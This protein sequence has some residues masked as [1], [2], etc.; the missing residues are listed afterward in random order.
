MSLLDIEYDH[1]GSPEY[2]FER[3]QMQLVVQTKNL[4][5]LESE[6]SKNGWTS[7]TLALRQDYEKLIT[8][9]RTRLVQ[10]EPAVPE[11]ERV[12]W[13]ILLCWR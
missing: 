11:I 1:L 9:L 8:H 4:A 2:E 12:W 6:S 10:F 13:H 7:T 3:I 5:I